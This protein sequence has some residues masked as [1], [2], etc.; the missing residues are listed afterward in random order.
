MTEG[1]TVS[2]VN[3]GDEHNAIL[4]F[5][6]KKGKD[7]AMEIRDGVSL[8]KGGLSLEEAI[9]E[10]GV[11]SLGEGNVGKPG[12]A[13]YCRL[14]YR[15]PTISVGDVVYVAIPFYGTTNAGNIAFYLPSEG[16]YIV[17]D[18]I[19]SGTYENGVRVIQASHYASELNSYEVKLQRYE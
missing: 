18:I 9:T 2:V 17:N 4:N 5:T 6:L 19:H 15:I 16:K 11:E 13:Y 14:R 1:D 12:E 7:Y 8:V 10:I 3:V